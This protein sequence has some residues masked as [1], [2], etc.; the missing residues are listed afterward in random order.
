[1]VVSGKIVR[2]WTEVVMGLVCLEESQ[3]PGE[4]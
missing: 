4:M 1:M 2:F 3:I